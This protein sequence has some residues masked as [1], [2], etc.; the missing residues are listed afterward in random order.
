MIVRWY[1][2]LDLHQPQHPGEEGVYKYDEDLVSSKVLVSSLLLF[3]RWAGWW[4]GQCLGAEKS[5]R[6]LSCLDRPACTP[7]C[8]C[9][10]WTSQ[11]V[12]W[13]KLILKCFDHIFG[14]LLRKSWHFIL[15]YKIFFI[16]LDFS[17]LIM[18]T[19]R[20]LALYWHESNPNAQ[21]TRTTNRAK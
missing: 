1:S 2:R 7:R 12:R 5:L 4:Y 10:E 19:T 18:P 11:S 20:D 21:W 6:G 14:G 15:F 16:W 8:A 3:C 13:S 17:K 9:R